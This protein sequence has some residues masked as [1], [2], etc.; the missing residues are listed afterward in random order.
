MSCVIREVDAPNYSGHET[1][2]ETAIAIASLTG[3]KFLADSKTVKNIICSNIAECSYAYTW[4]KPCLGDSNS[5]LYM[6]DLRGNF[7]DNVDNQVLGCQATVNF[8]NLFYRS[9]RQRSFEV[10]ATKFTNA[11][12]D[13]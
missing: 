4:I 13:K 10:F 1:S 6:V 8:D 12:D 2:E 3:D 7:S 11:I 9:E 5:R